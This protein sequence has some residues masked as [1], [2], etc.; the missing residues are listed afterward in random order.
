M[1]RGH[2][3][4]G[5]ECSTASGII[6]DAVHFLPPDT[7]PTSIRQADLIES[8]AAALQYIS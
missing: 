7:M 3:P 4:P 2:N 6:V 8:I 1:A 5:R